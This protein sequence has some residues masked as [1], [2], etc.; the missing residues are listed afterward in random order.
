MSYIAAAAQQTISTWDKFPDDAQVA[1]SS[2]KQGDTAVKPLGF[3]GHLRAMF[4]FK[5]TIQQNA[6]IT[7]EQARETIKAAYPELKKDHIDAHF[8]MVF[9]T[10][11]NEE[12]LKLP[13]AKQLKALTANIKNINATANMQKFEATVSK[14]EVPKMTFPALDT[15]NKI[16]LQYQPL[17]TKDDNELGSGL[18]QLLAQLPSEEDIKGTFNDTSIALHTT[19][20]PKIKVLQAQLSL[21]NK[22]YC[23]A[24]KPIHRSPFS[25]MNL[26]SEADKQK[27]CQ[28]MVTCGIK[29]LK[30][31]LAGKTAAA[32]KFEE[33]SKLYEKAV[34]DRY[35]LS[36]GDAVTAVIKQAD[37]AMAVAENTLR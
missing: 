12:Q 17:N 19:L 14:L 8:E 29:S 3:L 15:D 34:F 31:T 11:K 4:S 26:M 30:A 6:K 37:D 16:T 36:S 7:L 5:S 23:G 33:V 25:T 22:N 27:C 24:I 28:G 13:T 10:P 32:N 20:Q 2:N 1:L 18:S 21:I 35:T 9:P